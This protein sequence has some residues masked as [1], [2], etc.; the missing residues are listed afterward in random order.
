VID[1]MSGAVAICLNTAEGIQYVNRFWVDGREQPCQVPAPPPKPEG[2]AAGSL[3]V[4][5]GAGS[6]PADIE[7]RLSQL[8]QALD[9]QRASYYR[10]LLFNGVVISLG[11]AFWIGYTLYSNYRYRNEPPQMNQFVPVPIQVG[12]KTVLIGVGIAQW[13]VPQ[14][15]NATLIA[16]EREKQLLAEKAAQA[17]TNK[18]GATDS[19]TNATTTPK[20]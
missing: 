9:E 17:A 16:I 7:A 13:Q 8:I 3:P 4:G 15:L 20:P 2:V 5:D 19:S 1:P 11:V 12:D 6:A 10:F 18:D 14:E